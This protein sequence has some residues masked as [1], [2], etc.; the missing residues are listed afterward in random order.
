MLPSLNTDKRINNIINRQQQQQQQQ[1]QQNPWVQ[2]DYRKIYTIVLFFT[3]NVT[4]F[5]LPSLCL[6]F[7]FQLIYKF[8]NPFFLLAASGAMGNRYALRVIDGHCHNS[9]QVMLLCAEGGKEERRGGRGGWERR[10][11]RRVE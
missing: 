8:T 7:P 11:G 6:H 2:L 1:Q 3:D 5:V 10:E 9:R 4:A